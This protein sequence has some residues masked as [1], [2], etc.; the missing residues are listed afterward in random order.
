MKCPKCNLEMEVG[1]LQSCKTI[2]WTGKKHR[3]SIHPRKEDIVLADN[4]LGGAT[5][6]AFVCRNCELLLA[7]YGE[8]K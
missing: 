4:P 7:E 3:I 2:I 1:M 8:H 6:T 5:V